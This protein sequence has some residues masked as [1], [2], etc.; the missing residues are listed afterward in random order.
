MRTMHDSFGDV[1]AFVRRT[2][3]GLPRVTTSKLR[4]LLDDP[5]KFQ[6]LQLELA[7]TIDAMDQFVKTTYFLEGDGPLSL[8]A[9]E[10]IK[11]LYNCISVGHYPNSVAVAKKLAH[12]NPIVNNQLLTYAA[13]C[14]IDAYTYF[15]RK[16]DSDLHNAMELFKVARYFSPAKVNELKPCASAIAS[17]NICPFIDNTVI[18]K[19]QEELPTYLA[20]AEDVAGDIDTTNWWKNHSND[21]PQWSSI[22][23]LIILIQP[24]SASAERVFSILQSSFQ[25]QQESSLEDYIELSV[26][27]QYNYRNC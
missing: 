23:K 5:L 12:G 13:T 27:M 14:L 25:S 18:I 6:N 15:K 22:F 10:K 21:L 9:Y 4:E 20:A 11:A 19:L 26:M 1:V 16:F 3:V 8:Y 17:F 2:D 7:I 24:S